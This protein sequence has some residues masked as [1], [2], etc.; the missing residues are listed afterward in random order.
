[1]RRR[2]SAIAIA[3]R[4]SRRYVHIEGR[5]PMNQFGIGQPVRRVEDRRL[6]T[7]HGNYVDDQVLPRQAFPSSA[8]AACACPHAR[9]TL[10]PPQ[11]RPA[12]SRS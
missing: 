7:G 1:M 8:L 12:C 3:N 6:L 9:S 2:L 5:F 11:R 4:Q 10:R